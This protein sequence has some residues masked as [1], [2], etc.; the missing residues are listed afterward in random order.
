MA[1]PRWILLGIALLGACTPSEP[2]DSVA[3]AVEND[4]ELVFVGQLTAHDGSPLKAAHMTLTRSNFR[5]RVA[6]LELPAEGRFRVQLPGPGVYSLRVA[7]V[8]HAEQH[9]IF[10]VTGGTVELDGRLGTYARSFGDGE[11]PVRVRYLGASGEP[12]D[13][14]E[15]VAK[16]IEGRP[17]VYAL[18]LAPPAGA[19]AVQYQLVASSGRSFNG[20]A[21]QRFVYD[22]GG[23]YWAE[24]DLGTDTT[25]ELA[26]DELAPAGLSAQLELHGDHVVRSRGDEAHALLDEFVTELRE[27]LGDEQDLEAACA[28]VRSV[29]AEARSKVDAL[30]DTRLRA[31]AALAWGTLFGQFAR[32]ER[33]C[34]AAADL[35]WLLERVPA[36]H[37]AWSFLGVQIDNVF[38]AV[39]DDPK[40][41]EFRRQ[42]QTVQTDPGLRAHLLYLDLHE[43]GERE[44]EA[45][46]RALYAELAR[47][48]GDS[49]SLLYAR[50]TYD[51]DRPLQVGRAMPDWSFASLDGQVV[52]SA[53]LRGRPY[54]LEV[55]ATWCGPC[56]GEM[57]HLHAA[58]DALGGANGPIAFVSIS[59]DAH[60]ATVEA[61]RRGEWPMPWINLHQ[62]DE[63]SLF[64][65]WQ[66]SGIPLVVLV[67]AEG[68]IAETEKQLRGDKLLGTLQAFVRLEER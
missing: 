53:D 30:E 48:Y 4:A 54:L 7:G 59:T 2:S 34:L 56:V 58:W 57:K 55:W 14:I 44:D 61:F 13:A 16:P 47:D 28:V 10:A 5:T 49:Y 29:A 3:P 38:G 65:A 52:R 18:T 40:I 62:P 45:A 42:L 35:Y 11:L 20:P 27:Q 22:G 6:D 68:R 60:A 15:G 46:T 36:D 9:T 39:L 50:S 1:A 67:D 32:Q 8:D 64:A 31:H 23:D 63:A 21:A 51:P 43:A 37:L 66:F 25:L 19:T 33:A 26:L 41:G 17:Q 24:R 12:S